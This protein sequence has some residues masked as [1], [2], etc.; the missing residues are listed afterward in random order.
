MAAED[1][2]IRP[3]RVD[4]AQEKVA[5]HTS[6][7]ISSVRVSRRMCSRLVRRCPPWTG[8]RPTSAS[9]FSA[10]IQAALRPLWDRGAWT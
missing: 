8:H 1:H 9:L 4:I 7:I 2:T 5:E 10:G 6:G 3:F